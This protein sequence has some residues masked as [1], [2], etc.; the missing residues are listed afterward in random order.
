VRTL[1]LCFW[2]AEISK[3][4][5][6]YMFLFDDILLLTRVKK[7]SR[8]VRRTFQRY[9]HKM[10]VNTFEIAAECIKM[11]GISDITEPVVTYKDRFF[12]DMRPT[13]VCEICNIYSL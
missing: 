9:V 13:A 8:K 12:R 11:F 10:N 7:S 5:D 2:N 6:M 3:A 4:V 1:L